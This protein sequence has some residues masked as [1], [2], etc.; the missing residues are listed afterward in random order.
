M[1]R[2]FSGL[3]SV[4]PSGR[5][6]ASSSSDPFAGMYS[7]YYPPEW[8][9]SLSDAG[10]RVT[11][12][13]ALTLSAIFSGL[14]RAAGDFMR[15]PVHVMRQL[16]DGG[17]VRV[18]GGQTSG[19]IGALA[20]RLRWQPN[21]IQTAASFFACLVA[22]FIMRSRAYAEI[23]PDET[24]AFGQ[25]VP[26]HP[27]RVVN[28]ILPSGR[29]RFKIIEPKGPPR[30]VTQDEMLY[31]P[32]T[33]AGGFS[34]LSRIQ[35]GTQA[36]GTSL[37]AERAAARFY[38]SGMTAA[39][40]ATHANGEMEETEKASLHGDITRFAAGKDNSF[41]LMLVPE[42][43][44]ITALGIDP[45]K[46]QMMLARN[47]G[48]REAARL[49]LI[50]PELL[51][52]DNTGTLTGRSWEEVKSEY[53]TT[54]LGQIAVA[55]EQEMQRTLVLAKDAYVI[56]FL[57]DALFRGDL[58]SRGDYY[59]KALEGPWMWPSEIREKEGMNGDE[60]LDAIAEKRHRPADAKGTQTN[61]R[62]DR[63]DPEARQ[64]RSGLTARAEHSYHMLLHD[65]AVRVLRRERA[66]VEK[67][68]KKHASDVDGWHGG[69][70]DFYT[71]HAGFVSETMRL[72]MR[73]ARS[74]CAAHGTELQATGIVV[75]DEGWER[76]EADELVALALDAPAAA[77]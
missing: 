74:Y 71:E 46:A 37:A 44:K 31:V 73:T 43:I 8:N 28:E 76:R 41:G 72:D 69:L 49:L 58:K 63:E 48:I 25:L 68:A 32:D 16:D 22:Q 54:C 12:E 42:D 75:F 5:M 21:V 29:P 38:Q 55:F 7:G 47:Y 34:S 24:G 9:L 70:R 30:F 11:P 26:R 67:L 36:I 57:M 2:Y 52:A 40:L 19:G 51:F 45:D 6:R 17:K 1:G 62:R 66:A 59:Q 20:Y 50:P 14:T 18:R 27:D 35:Y 53:I 33:R 60:D 10:V 15:M 65:N 23:R 3:S 77:A 39:L 13:L 4:A 56:E 64:I 61:D